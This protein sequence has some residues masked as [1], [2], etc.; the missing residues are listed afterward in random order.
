MDGTQ[1][2]WTGGHGPCLSSPCA[3]GLCKGGGDAPPRRHM[4]ASSAYRLSPIAYRRLPAGAAWSLRFA[5]VF[6]AL[7][8]CLRHATRLR[9]FM[10]QSSR[11]LT[12][13]CTMD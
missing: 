10:F 2:R 4:R 5:A 3:E 6:L 12:T 1:L 9:L 8:R 7:M 13:E 11:D